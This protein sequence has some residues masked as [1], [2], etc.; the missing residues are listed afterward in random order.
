MVVCKTEDCC[1]K[2]NVRKRGDGLFHVSSYHDHTCDNIFAKVTTNWVRK[3][4]K[5]LL[6]NKSSIRPR[7][8]QDSIRLKYGV[9][10]A[11]WTSNRSL[12]K[13]RASISKV[14]EGFGK[15]AH[16]FDTLR[17]SDRA[18]I[19][20][21]VTQESRFHRAFLCPGACS[22]A[23][24][25]SLRV[26]GVDGCHMKT[27]Y[28]GVLLVATVLDGNSNIFPACIGIAEGE[29]SDSWTWF[30]RNV[31]I[32][33]GL[34]DGD[35]VVVLSDMEKGLERALTDVLPKALHGLCLFHIEKNFVKKFKSNMNG[36]L[37]KA[38]KCTTQEEFREC[39]DELEAANPAAANYIRLIEPK[40]RAWSHFPGRRF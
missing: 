24:G 8:L 14:E 20:D 36:V 25:L 9:N 4:A 32:S 19:T 31:R 5:E 33:L 16:L 23:F 30:L 37:W 29:S 17:E 34:G 38:A 7:E 28:G 39:I 26:V 2:V 40:K 35:G 18:T 13:A 1:Y 3:K 10:V 21:L 11:G 6:P 15:L 12:V 27:K 22:R